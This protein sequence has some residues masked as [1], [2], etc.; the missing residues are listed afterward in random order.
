MVV[1]PQGLG[2]FEGNRIFMNAN[3]GFKVHRGGCPIVRG[4]QINNGNGSG[5]CLGVCFLKS[6]FYSGCLSS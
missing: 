2:L 4:N 6:R 1:G 3:I 5:V